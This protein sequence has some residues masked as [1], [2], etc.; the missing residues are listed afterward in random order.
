MAPYTDQSD[1]QL[2][3]KI[4]DA[5]TENAYML[6]GGQMLLTK[7]IIKKSKSENELAM[8]ICHELGHFY[9][10]HII[11]QIGQQTIWS[12]ISSIFFPDYN[13]M[14]INRSISFFAGQSFRR[15]QEME[16][17]RF[18]LDCLHKK[19]GSR[20]WRKNFF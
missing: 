18:G 15:D 1:L 9:K 20:K 14:T 3:L 2:S 17:D 8:I 19:Y 6:F 11:T 7:E 10:R 16:A 5:P 12:I 4:I 13:T